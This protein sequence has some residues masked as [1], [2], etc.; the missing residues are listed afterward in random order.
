MIVEALLRSAPVFDHTDLMAA[1][2]GKIDRVT[3]W[4]TLQLFYEREMLLK[5]PSSD[6]VIRYMFRGIKG[7]KVLGNRSSTKTSRLELIC[8]NCGKII[9][10]NNFK[11]PIIGLPADFE[12]FYIDTI[13]NGKCSSCA[14]NVK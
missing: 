2:K 12:P 4:R 7:K 3:I 8:Q 9:S 14:K 13:I 6:G 11:L 1:C 5:I 10:V